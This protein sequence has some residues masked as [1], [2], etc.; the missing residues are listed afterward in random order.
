M[1][2]GS[3]RLGVVVAGLAFVAWPAHAQT[4][5]E[6]TVVDSAY[7]PREV[8]IEAGGTVTWTQT[9]TLPHSVTA[10]DGSFDS[11]PSCGSGACMGPGDTF[12]H[13]FTEPGTYAYYCRIHGGPGGAGMSGTVVV[14]AAATATEAPQPEETAPEE[15]AGETAPEQS[16]QEPEQDEGATAPPADGSDGAATETA[17]TGTAADGREAED[18]TTEGATAATSLPDTGAPALVLAL[19]A[20]AAVAGGIAVRRGGKSGR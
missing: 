10:D 7:E 6:V 19:S 20:L 13:T 14:A 16:D 1:R 2:S 12:Q 5:A 3:A 4:T 11:H 15:T 8:S 18:G 9:G 17:D